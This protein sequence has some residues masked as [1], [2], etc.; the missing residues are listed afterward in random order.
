MLGSIDCM[1]W[2][3]KSYTVAWQG[4]YCRGDHCKPTIIFE[5]VASQD[6][7]IWHAFFGVAGSNNDI[8]ML[9]Q[10]PMFDDILQGRASP[11]HFTIN[12]TPYNMGYY[13]A[14]GIHPD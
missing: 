2:E 7:W 3:W 6:L 4:Q 14:D 8:N 9:N 10:S 12:E 1:H 13:L 5:V 11:V